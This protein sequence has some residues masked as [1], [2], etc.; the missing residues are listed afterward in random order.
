MADVEMVNR[1]GFGGIDIDVVERFCIR[2][3]QWLSI[4]DK[5]EKELSEMDLEDDDDSSV[6]YE[7]YISRSCTVVRSSARVYMTR[8]LAAVLV[9]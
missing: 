5:T 8:S 4:C 9:N 7:Q 1:P 6:I 3:L 2:K